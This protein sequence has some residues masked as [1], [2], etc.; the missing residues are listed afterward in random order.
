[1][2]FPNVEG[3]LSEPSKPFVTPV[4]SNHNPAPNR[5]ANTQPAPSQRSPKMI[6]LFLLILIQPLSLPYVKQCVVC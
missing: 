5:L 2:T 3:F 6:Q 4:D 1:M